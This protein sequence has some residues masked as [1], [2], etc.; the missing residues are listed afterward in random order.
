MEQSH[1]L[2][3]GCWPERSRPGVNPC[4]SHGSCGRRSG[5][6]RVVQR[7][8][9]PDS[10]QPDRASFHRRLFSGGRFWGEQWRGNRSGFSRRTLFERV[11]PIGSLDQCA[12]RGDSRG[13][14]QPGV[15]GCCRFLD[16][17]GCS[18]SSL[19]SR[20]AGGGGGITL[21]AIWLRSFF[22]DPAA[23]QTE[24]SDVP[25]EIKGVASFAGRRMLEDSSAP[26]P[27]AGS[28][29]PMIRYG[30]G[31]QLGGVWVDRH[32]RPDILVG[33]SWS[34]LLLELW[35]REARHPEI[36]E[37]SIEPRAGGLPLDFWKVCLNE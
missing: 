29:V 20:S 17:P 12:V 30:T 28:K 1:Q 18:C 31:T 4:G 22:G 9:A 36:P 26:Y 25:L 24:G 35:V 11:L 14:W 6:E 23:R 33:E 37:L 7:W 15:S 8:N 13:G 19:G 32:P 34:G 5:C 16:Q 27:S 3:W 10:R 2:V 21:K